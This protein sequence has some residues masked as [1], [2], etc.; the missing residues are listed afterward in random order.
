MVEDPGFLSIV[1]MEEKSLHRRYSHVFGFLPYSCRIGLGGINS[2]TS[3]LLVARTSANGSLSSSSSG[4]LGLFLFKSSGTL[5]I[6]LY[7]EGVVGSLRNASLD[8]SYIY[9]SAVLMPLRRRRLLI[10]S[11]EEK[12]SEVISKG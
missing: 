11:S 9:F 7:A 4:D 1:Q 8:G 6:G 2:A 3:G 5:A 12:F 10:V